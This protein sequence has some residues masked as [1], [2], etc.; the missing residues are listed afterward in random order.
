MSGKRQ[1]PELFRADARLLFQIA[2]CMPQRFILVIISVVLVGTCTFR[3]PSSSVFPEKPAVADMPSGPL[4]SVLESAQRQIETTTQYTQDYFVIPYPNGDLPIQTGACTDV[5]I[6]S[7]RSAG[8]DLQ[9]EIHD[10]M[11]KNFESY[12]RKWGLTKPDTNI[13]HR[14]VP[15]LQ[16]FFERRGKSLPVTRKAN[17]YR[18]GDIVSWDLNGK[19]MTHIGLVSNRWNPSH[20]R[21]LIIHN[22]GSGVH[23]EDRL[24]EW[25]ITGH[26]RYFD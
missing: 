24:F 16:T 10:D 11:A 17:D 14:R 26:Y 21:Y 5:V 25:T 1:L 8:I 15:N 6:R 4:I 23:A 22:I 2:A 9:K 12:P 3:A 18:P 20:E 13:D 19:G 7:F